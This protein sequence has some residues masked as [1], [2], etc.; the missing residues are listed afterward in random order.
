MSQAVGR[1]Y[2][3]SV[4]AERKS[5]DGDSAIEECRIWF[6][7]AL[8]I[9]TVLP[10]ALVAIGY[11]VGVWAVRHYLTIPPDRIEAC[12][13]VW[14]FT[15][16]SCFVGM[17]SVPFHGM[18]GAK[19][20]IAELT[21]YSFVTTT[22]NAFYL[23]YMIT[24][25]GDW[26]AKYAGWT[27][28]MSVV[29]SLIIS[30]RACFKYPECR[31]RIGYLGI[32]PRIRE[33]AAFATFRAVNSFSQMLSHQGTAIVVNKLLGPASNAAMTIGRNIVSH[34][35]TLT[36]SCAGAMSPAVTNA[37]GE[38]DYDKMRKMSFLFCKLSA[39]AVMIF[40]VPLLCEVRNIMVIW[41]KTPPE[42]SAELCSWLLVS[43]FLGYLTNGMYV[44]ITANGEIG[45]YSAVS[46][47]GF[48]LAF[49]LSWLLM[50]L[51]L[52]IPAIG[53]GFV[54]CSTY[55][56]FAKLYYAKKLCGMSP[57]YWLRTILVPLIITFTIALLLGFLPQ[58]FN[59]KA[60]LLRVLVTT[61][62]C[63]STMLSLAWLIILDDEERAF[64][65]SRILP[66]FR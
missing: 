54:V 65:K 13:W 5:G 25:P 62:I 35:T 58:M 52:G 40:A 15:T 48:Y 42:G 55:T 37:A 34:A 9:H 14:R 64:V 24:H 4:G 27:C 46:S 1:Y 29:P 63:E 41:L 31:L 28:A 30:V 11:P 66:Y 7:T 44:A 17:S 3:F 22:L 8:T 50:W 10:L 23:Y 49:L 43:T 32:W 21:I 6:N 45:R 59:M 53:I 61:A 18:Y 39:L 19:Q 16:I 33:L 47:V 26:L 12:V 60:T 2:A 38:G 56:T 20:E 57:V 36:G 51:G